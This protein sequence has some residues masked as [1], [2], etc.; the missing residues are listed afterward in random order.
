MSW[1]LIAIA[2]LQFLL[3]DPAHAGTT[4]GRWCDRMLPSMPQY[5]AIITI[6]LNASGQAEG[7]I[8]FGD[9]SQ[10]TRALREASGDM[11]EIIDSPSGDK[12]RITP[13]SGD[14]QLIDNDGLIRVARR[15]ENK[16]V[17]R[18]CGF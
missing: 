10:T 12:Y 16:P 4:L 5:N 17:P 6:R 11:F 18:E 15:L 1:P 8:E 7:H 14:L 9:G 13:A 3:Q 2:L